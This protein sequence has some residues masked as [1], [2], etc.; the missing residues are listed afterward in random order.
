M[1][2]QMRYWKTYFIASFL[3]LVLI[4]QSYTV[5][6]QT[7]SIADHVIINEVETNPPG[8][9]SKLISQWVE[10]YNPTSN[11]VNIGG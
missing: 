7:I 4:G 5:M 8:D 6:G 2:V 10:L 11:P 3:V 1:V 9:D